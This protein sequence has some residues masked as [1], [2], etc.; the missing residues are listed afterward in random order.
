MQFKTG[1]ILVHISSGERY[2]YEYDFGPWPSLRSLSTGVLL[3]V[4][5]EFMHNYRLDVSH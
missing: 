3:H 1:Q 5:S 2:R 4:P